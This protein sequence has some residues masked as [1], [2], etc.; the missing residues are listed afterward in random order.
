M[1]IAI[2]GCRTRGL[3]ADRRARTRRR[4]PGSIPGLAGACRFQPAELRGDAAVR[5]YVARA[6]SWE[7]HVPAATPPT[8]AAWTPVSPPTPLQLERSPLPSLPA[9]AVVA[10][11]SAG[12]RRMPAGLSRQRR[13]GDQRA[14]SFGALCGVEAVP[15]ICQYQ[16]SLHAHPSQALAPRLGMPPPGNETSGASYR[17]ACAVPAFLRRVIQLSRWNPDAQSTALNYRA[18]GQK[19]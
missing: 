5:S 7:V 9:L 18:I 16:G 10:V 19:C 12:G 1:K 3:A 6:S 13:P 2:S 15:A 17:Q 4:L 14:G 11:L 8:A